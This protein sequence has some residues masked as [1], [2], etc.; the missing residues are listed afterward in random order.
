M[1]IYYVLRT[2]L[3]INWNKQRN[4]RFLEDYYRAS[5]LQVSNEIREKVISIITCFKGITLEEL[6]DYV[7]QTDD[8]Y[9]LIASGEIFVDLEKYSLVDSAE[10]IQVWRDKTIA[11]N[12]KVIRCN[13]SHQV[14]SALIS[15]GMTG[16]WDGQVWEIVNIGLT[17]IALYN[18]DKKIIQLSLLGFNKLVASGDFLI[19]E[20]HSRFTTPSTEI[21]EKADDSDLIEANRRYQIISPCLQGEPVKN[22][23]HTRRTVY[24]W[25]KKWRDAESKYGYGY[26]GLLPNYKN[27]G[28]RGSKLNQSTQKMID[29]FITSDYENLKQK[30]KF[31]VYSA[32][33]SACLIK[34]ITPIS[35]KTFVSK[36]N[37]H[38]TYE[39]V[40]KRQ[41]KRNAYKYEPFYWELELTTPRHGDRPFEIAH[42]D[43]TELDIELVS[44]RTGVN[45]GR[46]WVTFLSDAF[47]RRILATYLTFDPP[48]YRSCM[49]VIKEC[50][51]RHGR[52][53]NTLVVDGGKEFHSV[54]FETLLA[55]YCCTKKTR[56][57]AKPR[58]GSVCERLFG[59]ANT[60]LIHNLQ[61]NTQITRNP[62]GMTRSINPRNL[63]V[64]NLYSLYQNLC[65][66]AYEFYDNKEHPALGRSPRETFESGLLQTGLRSYK[67][68]PYDETFRIF[69]LPTTK[70]GTAKVIPN[71]GVKI[72]HIYYW[73]HSFRL[74]EVEKTQ[75][76]VRYDPYDVGVAYAYVKNQWFTC[77]SQHYSTFVGRS[78]REIM[79]VSQELRKQHKNHSKQFVV[80]ASALAKFLNQ[81]ELQEEILLQRMKDMEAK[82]IFKVIDVRSTQEHKPSESSVLLFPENNIESAE[83]IEDITEEIKPYEEFW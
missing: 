46:P 68:I 19:G 67:I 26:I 36:I 37:Q 42:I 27:R 40:E 76:S 5:D 82:D 49:M 24:Y 83:S 62:R 31:A 29:E 71:L 52:L 2:P 81:T 39:K 13:N 53:P 22:V 16:V 15:V 66:W 11:D 7:G 30:G 58:F 54:Y 23:N 64:W 34:G 43:H 17:K 56:P 70:K 60:N 69:T 4:L 75:V 10:K 45:L 80:T 8:V 18:E 65:D 50:V 6:L 21:F 48:S 72:N 79:L 41:G 33:R 57:A 1:G 9:T 35:Y 20:R 47:S 78:E 32:F 38:P 14:N 61:G 63:A 51:R 77:I 73:H 44:S 3:E 25:L 74:A 55:V 12:E 59:S 28:N